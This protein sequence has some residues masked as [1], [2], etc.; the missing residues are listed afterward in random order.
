MDTNPS[1]EHYSNIPVPDPDI[2]KPVSEVPVSDPDATKPD[3]KGWLRTIAQEKFEKFLRFILFWEKDDKRLGKIIRLIHHFIVYIGIIGYF[4]VHTVAPSYFI[5]VLFYIFWGLIWLHHV[6]FGGCLSSDIEAKLIGDKYDGIILPVL[7]IF[8]IKVT[9]ESGDGIE[10]ANGK[11]P[12]A[13]D[14]ALY[15][16]YTFYANTKTVQR[17]NLSF[18]TIQ[19]MVTNVSNIVI[20]DNTITLNSGDTG[21]P[22]PAGGIYLR[23]AGLIIN[24]GNRPDALLL[25]DETK[26]FKDSQTGGQTTGAYT[27][28]ND[29]NDLV[30]IYTNFIGTY[31]SDNLILLGSGPTGAGSI[32]SVVSVSGTTDYEKQVFPYTGSNITANPSNADGL[33]NPNDDDIIPNIKSC[34]EEYKKKNKEKWG[35]DLII[36]VEDKEDSQDL[37]FEE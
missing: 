37:T 27:F 33:S 22:E 28:A 4:V 35:E 25:F 26:V 9:P 19:N 21:Y 17:F 3:S 23:N 29:N 13:T 5:F 8:H 7:D 30:G 34:L 20:T 18:L 12:F 10:Q 14:I 24:R 1:A 2:A 31:S 6:I 16:N 36:T 32:T 11:P 15:K